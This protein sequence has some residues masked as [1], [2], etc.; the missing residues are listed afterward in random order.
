M[1]L[2][3]PPHCPR[4]VFCRVQDDRR[5]HGGV[6]GLLQGD[7]RGA[8]RHRGADQAGLSK[9]CAQIS[10]RRQQGAGRRGPIQGGGRGVRGAARAP[11]SAPPTI[12]WDRVRAP[13][14][15]FVR[16]R[17]RVRVRVQ[18]RR[19]RRGERR[20]LQRFFR[21]AVRPGRAARPRAAARHFDP[22]RGEDHHAKVLLDLERPSHG[23]SRS[24]TLRVPEIDAEGRLG[25]ARA[26]AQRAGA[27]GHPARADH[28]AGRPGGAARTR[29]PESG[30]PRRSVHRGRISAP[31]AVSG[32]R[33][34]SVPRS[35]GGAVGGRAR[36]QREDADARRRGRLEDSARI[37][38]RDANCG[39][40]A[41]ACPP[42]R[43]AIF[44]SCCKSPCRPQPTRRPRP[45]TAPWRRPCRSIPAQVSECSHHVL[46]PTSLV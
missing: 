38:C 43:R 27:E 36:R 14:R 26:R 19:T 37:A 28:P 8:R 20:G 4:I 42:R 41:A 22:G 5:C 35:A 2:F 9:A 23:G 46:H 39:S 7:G 16:P 10:S 34:R 29:R 1:G 13:A 33:P 11:R 18:R 32:R 44:T 24:F 21:V 15:I 25:D 45:P 3:D 6:Q 12:G 30:T 31:S 40:R 17:I